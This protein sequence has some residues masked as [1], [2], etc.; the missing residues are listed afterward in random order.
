MALREHVTFMVLPVLW[1]LCSIAHVG[2]RLLSSRSQL[3]EL[4]EGKE[5]QAF[6]RCCCRSAGGRASPT[7]TICRFEV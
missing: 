6:W 4:I 5:S 1:C 7:L 3:E 2:A